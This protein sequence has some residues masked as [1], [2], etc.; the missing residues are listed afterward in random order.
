MNFSLPPRH[1]L[2]SLKSLCFVGIVPGPSF[3]LQHETGTLLVMDR[4]A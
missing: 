4:L 3:R 1:A 2:R